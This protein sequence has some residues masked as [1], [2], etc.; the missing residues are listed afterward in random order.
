M[1][2]AF[3]FHVFLVGLWFLALLVLSMLVFSLSLVK[4]FGFLCPLTIVSKKGEKI[5]I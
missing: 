4:F 2:I 5:E 1:S 3:G